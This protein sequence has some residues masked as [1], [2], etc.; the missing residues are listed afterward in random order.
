MRFESFSTDSRE[1]LGAYLAHTHRTADGVLKKGRRLTANDIQQLRAAGITT[2]TAAV[3]ESTDVHEDAAATEIA[4]LFRDEHIAIGTAHTGRVNLAARAAGVV[5]IDAAVI[6]AANAIDESVTIATVRNDQVVASGAMIATIKI[7]PFA[8]PHDVLARVAACLTGKSPI[9]LHAFEPRNVGL[10]LTTLAHVPT[11]LLDRAS[12][13]QRERV[14]RLGGTLT[15]ERRCHHDVAEVASAI[16]ALRQDGAEVILVLGASAIV[17]RRDTIPAALVQCG[18]HVTQ[19][20]MPVDPGNLLMLGELGDIPVIGMPGCARSLA[21]SGLDLVLQRIFAS[22][23][24]DASVIRGMGVGGLY[25]PH[26]HDMGAPRETAVGGVVLAAGLS[27]RM[28]SNK[29]LLPVDGKPMVAHI[30]DAFLASRTGATVV[31]T[32]HEPDAVHAAL[33]GRDVTF[34]HNPDYAE[35]LAASVR[36]GIRAV[37]ELGLDG[38]VIGLGDMPFVTSATI[39]KLIDAFEGGPGICVS[40]YRRKRG[41]PVL[42]AARHFAALMTLEGDTGGRSLFARHA[43]D[44]VEVD[45]DE[46]GVML[47]VDTPESAAV[48]VGR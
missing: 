35:G 37:D 19:L 48:L 30:V 3:L 23:P 40:A 43:D 6:D 34:V 7:I 36:Y 31:V 4:G 21:P 47:D 15:L 25:K 41:N 38:A 28:G 9:A 5:R 20:G 2:V 16:H 11:R 14:R 13:A 29:L 10:L 26:H 42:W 33:V 24:V 44:L 12:V 17:D 39:D 22:L 32:G 1:L 27:S 46:E 45:V 8:V 18:G